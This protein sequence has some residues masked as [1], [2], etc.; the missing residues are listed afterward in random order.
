MKSGFFYFVILLAFVSNGC[1]SE[2][3]SYTASILK[4]AAYASQEFAEKSGHWPLSKESIY[5]PGVDRRVYLESI[6]YNDKL[7]NRQKGLSESEEVLPLFFSKKI[8]PNGQVVW[9][10]TTMVLEY[11]D[12]KDAFSLELG[13]HARSELVKLMSSKAKND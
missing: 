12:L 9:I 5:P 4:N 3:P 2:K 1:S 13:P 7:S 11:T 10:D 6:V 8:T